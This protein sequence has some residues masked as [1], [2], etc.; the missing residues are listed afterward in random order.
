V[1]GRTTS[2]IFGRAQEEAT[3]DSTLERLRELARR[4]AGE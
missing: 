4:L 3:V 2:R 1:A